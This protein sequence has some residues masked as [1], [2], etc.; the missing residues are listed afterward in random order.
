M[1]VSVCHWGC[2]TKQTSPPTHSP[3][4]KKQIGTH[5]VAGGAPDAAAHVD[6]RAE[7]APGGDAR[8]LERFVDHVHLPFMSTV[9]WGYVL[10]RG[11]DYDCECAPASIEC[12]RGRYRRRRHR[13]LHSASS[14]QQTP[15]VR[16]HLRLLVVPL[17][18]RVVPPVVHV[19]PPNLLPN[20]RRFVVELRDPVL[21]LLPPVGLVGWCRVVCICV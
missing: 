13:R 20:L 1:D 2:T 4:P 15:L 10:G 9:V 5:N 19:L 6:G 11:S 21:E 17:L 16:P 3:L 12:E 14:G 8:K 7:L 18:A